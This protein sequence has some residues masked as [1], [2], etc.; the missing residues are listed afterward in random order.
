MI[1]SDKAT[2]HMSFCMTP[3]AVCA[4][5]Y[6]GKERDAESGLD[7]FGARY[8]GSNMGRFSSPDPSGLFYADP[9]NPQSLNLYAYVQ[10]N[11]LVN[12]DPDGLDCFTTSNLTSTSVTVTTY[13]GATSCDGIAGGHYVDGTINT[14]SIG[15]AVGADGDVHV[16]FGYTPSDVGSGSVGAD[17]TYTMQGSS[18]GT[19]DIGEAIPG[20]LIVNEQDDALQQ[21]ATGVTADTQHSF[22]CIAGAYGIG[23]AGNGAA[24]VLGAP[25]VPKRF[26]GWGASQGTSL[27]S[28]LRKLYEGAPMPG[29]TYASPTGGLFSYGKPFEWKATANAGAAVARWAPYAISGATTAYASYKLWNCLG[30]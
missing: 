20:G 19:T 13:V 25:I 11:P 15:A 5:R 6:T 24:A 1:G 21:V 3:S 4:S 9:S 27:L 16:S 2:M 23:G 28:P 17:G 18:W 14:S 12:F 30:D 8:Y 7:Y 26:A 22:G 10:N 29:K